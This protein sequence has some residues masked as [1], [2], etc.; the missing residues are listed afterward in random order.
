MLKKL[1]GKTSCIFNRDFYS[2]YY[3]DF[4]FL[5]LEQLSGPSDGRSSLYSENGSIDHVSAGR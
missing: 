4:M 3:P 1:F 2:Y 5:F